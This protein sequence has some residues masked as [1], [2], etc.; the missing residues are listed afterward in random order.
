MVKKKEDEAKLTH[1]LSLSLLHPQPCSL[2]LF[3]QVKKTRIA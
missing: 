1:L 3:K 2:Q